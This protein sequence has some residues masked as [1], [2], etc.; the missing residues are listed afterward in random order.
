M[1]RAPWLELVDTEK[2][3]RHTFFSIIDEFDLLF[4]GD[5]LF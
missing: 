3:T 2:T 5:L 1:A 4:G